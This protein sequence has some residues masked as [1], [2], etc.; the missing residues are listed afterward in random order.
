LIRLAIPAHLLAALF[1]LRGKLHIW[2]NTRQDRAP[3]E[4]DRQKAPEKRRT[5][6][7]WKLTLFHRPRATTA[8]YNTLDAHAAGRIQIISSVAD[9]KDTRRYNH[10]LPDKRSGRIRGAIVASFA[11]RPRRRP[12]PPLRPKRSAYGVAGLRSRSGR[13]NRIHALMTAT[14]A[15]GPQRKAIPLNI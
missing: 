3:Q 13:P 7:S 2:H 1:F 6:H 11:Q 9:T 12:L 5:P 15:S 10:S 8:H 4:K 14:S